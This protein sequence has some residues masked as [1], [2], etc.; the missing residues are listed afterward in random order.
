M[1]KL[2]NLC[3]LETTAETEQYVGLGHAHVVEK[4]LSGTRYSVSAR[5]GTG[6]SVSVRVGTRHS[7]SVRI[8]KKI[9]GRQQRES[10]FINFLGEVRMNV[11][12]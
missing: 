5:M 4:H 2:A 6:H 10:F 1:L 9:D 8:R 11:W 12:F 3:N 7:V